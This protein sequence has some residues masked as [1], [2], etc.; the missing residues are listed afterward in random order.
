MS[1]TFFDLRCPPLISTFLAPKSNNLLAANIISSLFEILIPLKISAS[2][3]FG[4][5]KK[6]FFIRFF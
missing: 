1:S 5:I 4:V 3:I 6:T 2:G